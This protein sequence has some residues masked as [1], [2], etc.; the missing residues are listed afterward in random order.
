LLFVVRTA[1][2]TMDDLVEASIE[3]G[4]LE[5]QTPLIVVMGHQKCGA[6][7]AAVRAIESGVNPPAHLPE[8]VDAIRPAYTKGS[9][10]ADTIDKTIRTHTRL[11]AAALRED[12]AFSDLIAEGALLIRGA[13]YSLDTGVVSWLA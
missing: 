10:E 7:T 8:I 11:T 3:Y 2:H 1:A 6:V 12:N 9:D 4:P 5:L 13:Y